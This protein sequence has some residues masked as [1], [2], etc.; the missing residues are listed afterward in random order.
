MKYSTKVGIVI[1]LAIMLAFSLSVAFAGTE[2]TNATKSVNIT[3]V[4][5]NMTNVTNPFGHAKGI[6][7]S[8]LSYLNNTSLPSNEVQ[9]A[10][11][12]LP[13]KPPHGGGGSGTIGGGGGAITH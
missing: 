6:L 4:T 7:K 11:T 3:N 8:N 12:K 13:P 2:K 10:S 1:F 9:L 5:N